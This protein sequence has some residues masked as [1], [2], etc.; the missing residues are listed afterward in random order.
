M[1]GCMYSYQNEESRSSL[2]KIPKV[3]FPIVFAG[4]ERS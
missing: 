1:N 3:A 2:Q 4:G